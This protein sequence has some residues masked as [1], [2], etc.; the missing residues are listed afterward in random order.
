MRFEQAIG[1]NWASANDPCVKML[2]I[3][4][5]EPAE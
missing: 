5:Q 2:E 1:S 4:G 3:R